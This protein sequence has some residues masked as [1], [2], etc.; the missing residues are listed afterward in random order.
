LA[1]GQQNGDFARAG[2][3]ATA[4]LVEGFWRLPK[5]FLFAVMLFIP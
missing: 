1:V 5:V 4:S 3:F 2:N